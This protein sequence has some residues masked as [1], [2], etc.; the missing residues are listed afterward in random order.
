MDST[1]ILSFYHKTWNQ[2]PIL[3]KI[4]RKWYSRIFRQIKEGGVI[5]ELGSGSGMGKEF[6]QDIIL[7]DIVFN[8]WLDI[9]LNGEEFPVNAGSLSNIIMIDTLHHLKNPIL[10][11]KEASRVLVDGGKIIA[12]EPYTGK[13]AYYFW[14]YLHHEPVDLKF[15][16][17]KGSPVKQEPFDSNQAI[18]YLIFKNFDK[19]KPTVPNFEIIHIEYFDLLYYALSGGFSKPNLVPFFMEDIIMAADKILLRIFRKYISLRMMLVIE[20]QTKPNGRR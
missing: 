13:F 15:N 20:K 6:N 12:I 8:D 18:P 2:K 17:L 1:A 4:Y 14:N 5:L 11:L 19:I 7:G 9:A 10:F 16:I 3:Q